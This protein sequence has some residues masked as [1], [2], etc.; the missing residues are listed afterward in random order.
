MSA[1]LEN[2]SQYRTNLFFGET[3]I[4]EAST[5]ELVEESGEETSVSS[6]CRKFMLWIDGVGG[7]QLCTGNSFIIGA[8]SLEKES[9]DIAL[10]ANVS[11]QHASLYCEGEDWRLTA[12]QP[13]QVA[14]KLIESETVIRS[15]D[16]ICMAERVRLGFRIPSV[17]ST[18]AVIDFES[19]HRPSYSVDGIIL[20]TD[21]CLLGPRRD[22]HIY[23]S[24]W[25]DLVVLFEQDGELR[26]RSNSTLHA[27]GAVVRDSAPLSHGTVITGEELRFR[28]EQMD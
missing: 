11:R 21:H 6:Q 12:H 5:E 18:A 25:P 15:G 28:V 14:G 4:P 16:Q 10:L 7:W 26:C 24:H 2:D 3:L 17:L 8:P 9:A 27:D 1:T 22:H 23:C 13:T 20:L 19:D